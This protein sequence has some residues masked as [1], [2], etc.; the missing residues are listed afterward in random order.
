MESAKSRWGVKPKAPYGLRVI[1]Y[2]TERLARDRDQYFSTDSECS[3]SHF[4]K[5]EEGGMK[6][7][8]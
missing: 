2:K 3:G 1:C 5:A 6:E 4:M 7:N 8:A